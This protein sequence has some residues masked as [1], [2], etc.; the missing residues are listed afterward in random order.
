MENRDSTVTD[1]DSIRKEVLYYT[2]GGAELVRRRYLSELQKL[3]NND[4]ISYFSAYSLEEDFA[5]ELTA[6]TADDIRGF[7]GSVHE[8]QGEKL[9]LIIHSPG[10]SLEGAEQIVS[11]LR[12][13]YKYI[14]AIVPQNAM[15]AA[16]MI[17]CA[18]DEIIMGAYSAIGPIDPQIV[19]HGVSLPAHTILAD[20]EDTLCRIK[21]D[22]NLKFLMRRFI[23]L[24]PGFME[25]CK[26]AIVLSQEKVQA[27]LQAY[28]F[29]GA[30]DSPA[31][32]IATWLGDF[33][34]HRTHGRP[35][36]FRL[37]KEKGL[38]VTR[39]EDDSELQNLVLAIFHSTVV[40][41]QVT[42]CVKII[43]NHKG[44]SAQLYSQDAAG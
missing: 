8:L 14:R 30:A 6:I 42:G 32:A 12:E 5:P 1:Y 3:T 31:Q 36:G 29:E 41:C 40:T 7:M 19:V 23:G 9:D 33:N 11:Y 37:A 18:C 4:V 25:W 2:Q 16:T 22:S 44:D 15:S 43:E 17:A 35:I 34:E 38:K 10:G 27:W 21:E 24:P 20:W 13:K 26:Q 28:M 39:L